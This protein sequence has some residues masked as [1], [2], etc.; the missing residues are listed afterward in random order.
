MLSGDKFHTDWLIN[1]IEKSDISLI[2]QYG[3]NGT[4]VIVYTVC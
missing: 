4:K 3:F 1:G 2:K